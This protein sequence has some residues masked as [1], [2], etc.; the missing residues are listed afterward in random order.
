MSGRR[1]VAT[2]EGSAAAAMKSASVIV[3]MSR[4]SRAAICCTVKPSGNVTLVYVSLGGVRSRP[5]TLPMWSRRAI[6]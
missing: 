5:S 3:S 1:N 4:S 2:S 6:S